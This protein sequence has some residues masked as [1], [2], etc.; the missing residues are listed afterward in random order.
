MPRKQSNSFAAYAHSLKAAASF[1]ALAAVPAGVG[2]LVAYDAASS[3]R[4]R[5]QR[6][7]GAVVEVHDGARDLTW[8]SASSTVMVAP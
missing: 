2:A 5:G 8:S 3:P 7:V 1:L 4:D 6:A